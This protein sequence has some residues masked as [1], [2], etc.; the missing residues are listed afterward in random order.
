MESVD[1]GGYI[2]N[3]GNAS[4]DQKDL[5]TA[6]FGDEISMQLGNQYYSVSLLIKNQQIDGKGEKDMVLY[7]TADQLTVGG[8][9]WRN[10]SWRD[11]NNVPVYGLVFINNKK[12]DYTFCDHMFQGEAPVCDFGGALGTGNVGNFNTNLW[13]ST[14]FP[15]VTDSSNGQITQSYITK[16]GELDDAYN[17]YI[18]NQK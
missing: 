15:S 8:G 17:Y 16:D 13:N 3:V 11:L 18:K 5:I 7:I 9:T 4:Q 12:N 1:T 10:N 6:I 14:E 2:G